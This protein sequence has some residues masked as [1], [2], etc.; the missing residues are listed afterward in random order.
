MLD[1]GVNSKCKFAKLVINEFMTHNWSKKEH[2]NVDKLWNGTIDREYQL[3]KQ[4]MIFLKDGRNSM[5][6]RITQ[7]VGKY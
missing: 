7:T 4:A 3:G 2:W 6:T 5:T 1:A